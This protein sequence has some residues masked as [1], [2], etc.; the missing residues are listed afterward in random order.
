MA[1]VII[2]LSVVALMGVLTTSI[3]SSGEY[4]SLITVDTVLKNFA[5]AVKYETEIGPCA[6]DLC[7]MR[8]DLSGCE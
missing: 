1:L 7:P 2:G 6:N 3:S 4:R 8:V 5:G